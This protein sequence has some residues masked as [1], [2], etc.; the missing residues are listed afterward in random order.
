MLGA[1]FRPIPLGRVLG[2]PVLVSPAVLP[3][4]ALP[5]ALAPEAD[6]GFVAWLVVSLGIGLVAHELAH[7]LV[8]RRLGLEVVDVTLGPMGGVARIGG[9]HERPQLEAPVAL[10]GPA[11]N[12]LLAAAFAL[13]GDA[14]RGFAM[15]NLL[16]GA[17]NLL[18][19]FP[20]DGGRILR[21]FLARRSPF[22]DATRAAQPTLLVLA[23][24]T[25]LVCW[26]S[27]LVLAPVFLA[28]CLLV[29]GWNELARAV[30]AFGPPMLS[31]GEVWRRAFAREVGAAS[32][33]AAAPPP[34]RPDAG[35]EAADGAEEIAAEP[36]SSDLEHFRGSLDEFFRGRR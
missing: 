31:R 30:L 2:I 16:L 28:L 9:L 32:P 14:A 20:L 23:L 24:A 6:A 1:F 17:G 26:A 21:G 25:A 5:I 33:S 8:A 36:V 22:V 27:G 19:L 12:L 11:A 29:F 18:P 3:L 15:V 34:V 13:P 7:A 10:A 35:R 4:L